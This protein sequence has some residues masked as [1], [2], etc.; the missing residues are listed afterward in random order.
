MKIKKFDNIWIM[1]LILCGA[2]LVFLYMLKIFFPS[3]VVETAQSEKICKIGNYIDTHK[4]A[5]YLANSVLSF[6]VMSLLCCSACRK[7]TLNWKEIL[8]IVA[9]IAFMYIIKAFLPKYY[10]AFNYISMILLPCIMGARLIPTTITFVSLMLVQTFTLEIRNIGLMITDCNFATLLILVIDVYLFQILLY[11][12]MNY[13][14]E[15]K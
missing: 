7:K 14:R 12:A 13:K 5:W 3:F 10:T 6:I 2:I 11:L 1:G 15:E 9:D 4:W 8:I